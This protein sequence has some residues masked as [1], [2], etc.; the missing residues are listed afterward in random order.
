MKKGEKNDV[1]MNIYMCVLLSCLFAST[2]IIA[3]N[4]WLLLFYF[5]FS[6]FFLVFCSFFQIV[7]NIRQFV[8]APGVNFESIELVAFTLHKTATCL[9]TG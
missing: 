5:E 4:E 3:Q 1:R 6:F 9:G 2:S 7:L 8:Q